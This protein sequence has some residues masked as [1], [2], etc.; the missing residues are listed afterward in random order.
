MKMEIDFG[1][2][3]GFVFGINLFNNETD[4]GVEYN[5]QLFLG[6]FCIHITW[7]DS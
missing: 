6:I 7:V 1:I 4:E 2:I 3:A 5:A